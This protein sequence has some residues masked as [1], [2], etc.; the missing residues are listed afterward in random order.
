MKQSPSREDWI[1]EKTRAL[2]ETRRFTAVLIHAHQWPILGQMIPFQTLPP[3][4][5]KIHYNIILLSTGAGA[6]PS[7]PWPVAIPTLISRPAR[8]FSPLH[9]VHIGTAGSSPGIKRPGS[10]TNHTSP[11]SAEVKNSRFISHSPYVFM[12]WCLIIQA[13]GQLYLHSNRRQDLPKGLFP[14]GFQP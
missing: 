6:Q 4:Y 9:R 7:S 1:V 5:S 14:S 2:Y 10:D 8:D 11:S 3:W 13:Q 12:A